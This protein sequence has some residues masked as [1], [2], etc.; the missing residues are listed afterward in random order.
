M[1]KL[2][3][4]TDIIKQGSNYIPDISV[5]FSNIVNEVMKWINKITWF[6]WI[7][8]LFIVVLGFVLWGLRVKMLA[9]KRKR[10]IYH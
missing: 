8:L 3:K 9:S 1:S 4:T 7:L 6:E 5:G 2:N 10:T